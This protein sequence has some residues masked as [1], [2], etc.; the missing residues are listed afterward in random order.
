MKHVEELADKLVSLDVKELQHLKGYLK[1]QYGLEE[2]VPIAVAQPTVIEEK[3]VVEKA[4]FDIIL[5][6]IGEGTDKLN[7]VKEINKLTGVGLKP[8][9]DLTKVLPSVLKEKVA[10][11]TAEEFKSTMEALNANIELK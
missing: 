4:E 2:T 3:K 11:A 10:R 7:S 9:M 8:A 6:K 1:S 5:T